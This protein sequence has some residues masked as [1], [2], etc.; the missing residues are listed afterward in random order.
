MKTIEE[1]QG[2]KKKKYHRFFR[3]KCKCKLLCARHGVNIQSH[4]YL[5]F[6]L[7]GGERSA[8]CF[9]SGE[10][11]PG[12]YVV[13]NRRLGEPQRRSSFFEEEKYFL[14]CRDLD[15][16]SSVVAAYSPVSMSSTVI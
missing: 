16:Y 11:T 13:F 12:I 8:G 7:D 9:T 14:L 2:R 6:A 5:N 10:R 1:A 4:S 3:M 15:K